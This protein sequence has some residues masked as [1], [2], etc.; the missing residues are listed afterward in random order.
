MGKIAALTPILNS[1][2][3]QAPD[4]KTLEVGGNPVGSPG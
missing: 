2:P 1:P 4:W 3:K